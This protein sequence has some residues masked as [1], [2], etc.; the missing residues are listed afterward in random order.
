[1]PRGMSVCRICNA[2]MPSLYRRWHEQVL[3][4]RMRYLRGDT[5]VIDRFNH[6]PER[7]QQVTVDPL[8]TCLTRYVTL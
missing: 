6:V 2:P 7:V 8:Q 4:L 3:C 5:D 1:M